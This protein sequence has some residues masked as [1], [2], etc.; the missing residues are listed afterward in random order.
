[1]ARVI[2]LILLVVAVVL[3]VGCDYTLEVK[4][5]SALLARAEIESCLLDRM[6]VPMDVEERALYG[7]SDDDVRE[8]LDDVLETFLVIVGIGGSTDLGAV[9]AVGL[10]FGCMG[11]ADYERFSEA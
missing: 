10:L 4:S 3:V 2:V 11:P 6:D 8:I 5:T 9:V 1:M 7:I